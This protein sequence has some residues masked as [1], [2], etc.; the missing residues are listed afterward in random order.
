[1]VSTGVITTTPT[2]W[3][4]VLARV[5]HLHTT[6]R[7]D[8]LAEFWVVVDVVAT[9]ALDGHVLGRNND[10]WAGG[11]LDRERTRPREAI[12]TFVRARPCNSGSFHARRSSMEGRSRPRD[13]ELGAVGS[14]TFGSREPVVQLLAVAVA[15]TLNHLVVWRVDLAHFTT[16]NTR[17]ARR[18][19]CRVPNLS[20]LLV[21]RLHCTNNQ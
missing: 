5:F 12:A 1:M 15:V 11:I 7:F 20:C 18:W 17:G 6:V 13:R 2:A 3:S 14:T 4:G 8:P 9:G 21:A 16:E 10:F 19:I